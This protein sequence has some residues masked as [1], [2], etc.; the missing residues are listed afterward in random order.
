MT[1]AYIK[2]LTDNPASFK[3]IKNPWINKRYL[4]IHITSGSDGHSPS[5][6]TGSEVC[7]SK[8]FSVYPL[9][10]MT[11]REMQKASFTR[12]NP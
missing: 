2:T 1:T 12:E 10:A 3:E 11:A 6:K 4:R 9:P 8:K 5:E 7:S